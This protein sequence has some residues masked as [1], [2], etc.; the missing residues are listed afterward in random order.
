[1]HLVI[2]TSQNPAS[3]SRQLAARAAELLEGY[4]PQVRVLDLAN[5]SLPIHD[6]A[7]A[8]SADEEKL[9]HR[10]GSASGILLVMPV[11]YG[12][13]AVSA[14]NLLQLAGNAW[15]RKVVGLATV[16]GDRLHHAATFSLANWLMTEQ[17]AFIVPDFVFAERD[18]VAASLQDP[19][20][21]LHE[22]LRLLVENLARM[23]SA[24]RQA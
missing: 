18:S 22:Q 24:L 17:H 23:T 9:R 1:M 4:A 6:A 2:S 14:R 10:V 16:A 12:D 8:Q 5:Y 20:H 7:R 11:H 21:P 13:V 19:A 3:H 15:H